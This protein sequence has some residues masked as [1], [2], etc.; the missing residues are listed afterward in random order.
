MNLKTREHKVGW[1]GRGGRCQR[2]WRGSGIQSNYMKASL[3]IKKQKQKKTSFNPK[4]ERLV[5][6]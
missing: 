6:L 4:I 3:G 5:D 1:V 2:N